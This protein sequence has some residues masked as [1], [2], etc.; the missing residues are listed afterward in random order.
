MLKQTAIPLAAF[1]ITG[2]TALLAYDLLH[3]AI[4]YV[5]FKYPIAIVMLYAFFQLIAH[6]EQR[7]S[8]QLDEVGLLR[9]LRDGAYLVC[10]HM[11]L[12]DFGVDLNILSSES[13]MPVALISW[14]V[15]LVGYY[16]DEQPRGLPGRLIDL[17]PGIAPTAR[18]DLMSWVRPRRADRRARH[19][20]GHRA[21]PLARHPHARR[22]H[23]RL[24]QIRGVTVQNDRLDT[25]ATLLNL[26]TAILWGGN[27]VSIKLGLAGIPPLCL[28][29]VRFLLG[30]IVVYLWTRPLDLDLKLK[31]D[32]QRGVLGLIVIFFT[33]IYLLNMGT[34]YTLASRS[35]IFI[36]AYPFFT[37]LFAHLFI[38]G[39]KNQHAQNDRHDPVFPRR[40]AHLC[41]KPRAQRISTPLGRRPRARQRVP[42]RR[43]PSL[44]Q[45]A[46][47]K[48]APGKSPHLAIRAQLAPVFRPQRAF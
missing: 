7:R 36:S 4:P 44:S 38:P 16:A 28:A 10:L 3:Y 21:T 30:G 40:G 26:L 34:A 23:P 35:T 42:T 20:R 19:I 45:A 6:A 32:E 25:R 33:Q 2:S 22:L 43:A 41:R 39:D 18:R 13:S 9:P 47:P 15:N 5:V 11:H 27:S 37:A 31:R 8:A 1:L 24:F 17:I 12:R 14:A 46:H 29:G 48:H